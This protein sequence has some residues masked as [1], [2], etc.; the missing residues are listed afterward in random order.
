MSFNDNKVLAGQEYCTIAT[1]ELDRCRHTTEQ[2]VIDGD[3]TASAGVTD[4]YTGTLDIAGGTA[5]SFENSSPYILW[6]SELIKA[7]VD[8]DSQLKPGDILIRDT[9]ETDSGLTEERQLEL[10][11]LKES[12]DSDEVEG[13]YITKKIA[14]SIAFNPSTRSSL[15]FFDLFLTKFIPY[16]IFLE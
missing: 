3:I 11:E 6:D 14:E 9:A 4:S 16:A 1:I 5:T 10:L 13:L 8:S 7:T 15:C 12:M 2:S